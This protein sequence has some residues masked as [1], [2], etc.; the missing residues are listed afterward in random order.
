MQAEDFPHFYAAVHGSP[1][2]PWQ[3]R[4]AQ[5]VLAGEWPTTLALPTASGK[6]SL[7]DIFTFALA[8][9]ATR[10]AADRTVPLR[11]VFV[12][13]RRLVVDEAFRHAAHLAR[14]LADGA[15]G[16]AHGVVT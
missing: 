3:A 16:T 12:V 1:P 4:L 13:D 10:P 15:H 2:F 11:L 7:V 8:M 9:Q 6:T 14:A 5:A